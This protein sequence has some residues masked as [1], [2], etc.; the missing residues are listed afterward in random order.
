MGPGNQAATANRIAPA[1]TSDYACR[2]SLALHDPQPT[3]SSP[4][5]RGTRLAVAVLGGV[6]AFLSAGG[7]WLWSAHGGTL[8]FDMI[9]TGLRNC[10]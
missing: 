5:A 3:V 2:M 9:V 7:V 10:F 4:P 6:L 1:V 8:F